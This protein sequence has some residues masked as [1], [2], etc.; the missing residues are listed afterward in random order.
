MLWVKI[1]FYFFE[2]SEE[3][4]IFNCISLPE[5]SLS[6]FCGV[7]DW[8]QNQQDENHQDC[9]FDDGGPHLAHENGRF[10]DHH[11]DHP[12]CDREFLCH[13]RL[14]L[15]VVREFRSDYLGRH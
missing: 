12:Y 6:D 14:F 13:I 8:S 5:S 15:C 2:I 11:V 3:K 10:W 4:E 1:S 9:R 7:S